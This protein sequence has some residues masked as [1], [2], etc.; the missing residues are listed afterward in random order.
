MFQRIVERMT[1]E[2]L[3]LCMMTVH[4]G[5]DVVLN[6]RQYHTEDLKILK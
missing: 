5:G 4:H 1:K 2:L 6:Q 3:T